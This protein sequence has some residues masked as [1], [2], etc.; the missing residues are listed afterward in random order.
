MCLMLYLATAEEQ[1]L[2][3]SPELS[4]EAIQSYAGPVRQWFSLP[5]IRYVGAHTGCSCGFRS[6]NAEE[7]IDYW[8]GM[9]D[10]SDDDRKN[11]ESTR[12]LVALIR[13]L[14]AGGAVEMYPV[15]AGDEGLSPK[16][17]IELQAATLDPE[18]FFLNERFLYRIYETP[19]AA[20]KS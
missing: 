9:F 17:T 14:A 15:W 12:A 18:R 5:A 11:L 8:E 13:G 19:P 10:L 20:W 16:R 3:S 4:V 2:R 6:V 7:P 1:P